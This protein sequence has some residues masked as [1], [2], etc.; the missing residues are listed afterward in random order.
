MHTRALSASGLSCAVNDI[1][2]VSL[3]EDGDADIHVTGMLVCHG[4]A[5]A[6]T[7][8]VFVEAMAPKSN[9]VVL[10]TR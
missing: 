1:V 5:S 10:T 9:A 8:T 3:P 4:V 7:S 6:F 2:A